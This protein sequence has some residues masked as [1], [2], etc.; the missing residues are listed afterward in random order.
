MGLERK[1][2]NNLHFSPI[3]PSLY[4]VHYK[5]IDSD[6]FFTKVRAAWSSENNLSPLL[7]SINRSHPFSLN[8]RETSLLD[9]SSLIRE[10][11]SDCII[12]NFALTFFSVLYRDVYQR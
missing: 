8:I 9:L 10:S 2:W 5:I 7:I 11:S 6:I 4:A 1:T 3:I 12:T